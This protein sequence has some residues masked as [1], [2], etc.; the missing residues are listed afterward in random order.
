MTFDVSMPSN[1]ACP[2]C[3]AL[4]DLTC[5]AAPGCSALVCRGCASGC[6]VEQGPRSRCVEAAE[7]ETAEHY[8]IRVNR[9]RALFGLAPVTVDHIREEG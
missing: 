6:D 2:K 9:A 5:C 7:N 4:M 3:D 1:V 8:V